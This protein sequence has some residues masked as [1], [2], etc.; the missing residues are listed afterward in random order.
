[1]K[2]N[3]F[4]TVSIIMLV[5]VIFLTGQSYRQAKFLG[6][7]N[8][9]WD[10]ET[11]FEYANMLLAKGLNQPAAQVFE[12]YLDSADI[13]VEKQAKI[14]YRLG[15]VFM[16]G[17]D[18]ERALQYFYRAEFL[19]KDA[20]YSDQMNQKIVEA[21]EK[22]GMSNQARQE[23]SS[24]VHLGEDRKARGKIVARIGDR[25][26]TEA[27][28]EAE[29]DNLPSWLKKNLSDPD[30][31]R[32]FINEY[33]IDEVL[34]SKARRLAIDKD[35]RVRQLIDASGRQ[36]VVNALILQEVGEIKVTPSDLELY[37]NANKDKYSDPARLKVKYL[38]FSDS[39]DK[40]AVLKKLRQ[41]KDKEIRE[42]LISQGQNYISGIGKAESVIESLFTRDKGLVS[43]SYRIGDK[44]YVFS[45]EDKV[46]RRVS[47]FDEVKQHVEYEYRL[48]KQQEKTQAFLDKVM[49]E[50]KVE[51]LY[52]QRQ[53]QE[54]KD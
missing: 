13:D 14:C 11:Q 43:D 1:M 7:K 53:E 45:V 37:Y 46:K 39:K 16:D 24:R 48:R 8:N 22:L 33:V 27:E 32:K 44:F 36:I 49:E 35:P 51:I 26:I 41:G 40:E 30:N 34:Y 38:S 28:I 54:N 52:D 10:G 20:G 15:T 50:Q 2:Q 29:I 21:L 42:T 47:S 23:L 6:R 17:Y 25:E 12:K 31:R 9:Y 5:V 19:D 3:I 4:F 18:Y